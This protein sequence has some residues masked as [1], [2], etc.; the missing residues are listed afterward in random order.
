MTV[1]GTAQGGHVGTAVDL[2]KLFRPGQPEIRT[3]QIDACDCLAQVVIVKQRLMN[4]FLKLLVLEDI[5]PFGIG[6]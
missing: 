6:E 3:R 1:S 4:Q 2:W 5:E